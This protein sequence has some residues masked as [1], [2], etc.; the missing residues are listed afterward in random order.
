MED[1]Q[2]ILAAV[3]QAIGGELRKK[4][5]G[6]GMYGKTCTGIV[7]ESG[8]VVKGIEMAAQKGIVG[9]EQDQ[10]GL[11]YIVYWPRA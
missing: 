4:Y 5:S 7:V 1:N 8:D 6:R 10:M 9:A 11:G 3:A 2:K